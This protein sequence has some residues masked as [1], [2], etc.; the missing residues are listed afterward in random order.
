MSLFT[1]IELAFVYIRYRYELKEFKASEAL[2]M[3]L[4]LH[5]FLFKTCF[6]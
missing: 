3:Y 6:I 5:M 2:K 1:I 4:P